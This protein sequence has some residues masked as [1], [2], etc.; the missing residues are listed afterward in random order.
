MNAIE[1]MYLSEACECAKGDYRL[2]AATM[3]GCAA[4]ILLIK[5]SEAFFSYMQNVGSSTIELQN[6]E[7]KVIKSS[8]SSNRLTELVNISL[9]IKKS[10]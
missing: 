6:F 3:L 2:A 5:L 4:E 8:K 9:R 1:K 10:A 7:K